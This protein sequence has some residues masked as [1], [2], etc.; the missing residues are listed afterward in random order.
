MK[1]IIKSIKV[2]P[3]VI[4]AVALGLFIGNIYGTVTTINTVKR[5]IPNK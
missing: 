2:E 1:N 5:M 4:Y 3:N